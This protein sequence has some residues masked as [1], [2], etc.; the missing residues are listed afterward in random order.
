MA[1]NEDFTQSF[2]AREW[3]KAFVERV[4]KNPA[5]ATDEGTMTS[6]FA[7]AIMRGYDEHARRQR[8]E[9]WFPT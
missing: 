9:E 5:I 6:W 1:D 7:N 3:A 8:M 2:D 4:R